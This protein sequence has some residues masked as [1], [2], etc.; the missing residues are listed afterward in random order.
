MTVL[1]LLFVWREG[2]AVCFV[3]G[4]TFVGLTVKLIWT[5][6]TYAWVSQVPF[7]ISAGWVQAS[8]PERSLGILC[9]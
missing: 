6:H 3:G 2:K 5:S 9:P 7:V 8:L 4:W 1:L